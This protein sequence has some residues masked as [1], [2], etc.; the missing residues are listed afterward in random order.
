M[1]LYNIDLLLAKDESLTQN[2]PN[3][4]AIEGQAQDQDQY[5]CSNQRQMFT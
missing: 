3:D 1:W 2:H 4:G 5:I